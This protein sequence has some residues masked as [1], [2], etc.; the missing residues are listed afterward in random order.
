MGVISSSWF[1]SRQLLIV[2]FF[3]FKFD[4]FVAI[5]AH[6][7]TIWGHLDW[8]W[9][10]AWSFWESSLQLEILLKVCWLIE[11]NACSW[12]SEWQWVGGV[13]KPLVIYVMVHCCN[14]AKT[15]VRSAANSNTSWIIFILLQSR[16]RCYVRPLYLWLRSDLMLPYYLTRPVIV[17]VCN[18]MI[19]DSIYVDNNITSF[20]PANYVVC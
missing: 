1:V 4:H 19:Q 11:T 6:F 17:S 10:G 14:G 20:V 7:Y 18:M 9:S 13:H 3:N 16:Y 12:T 15:V 8:T 2:V 5:A